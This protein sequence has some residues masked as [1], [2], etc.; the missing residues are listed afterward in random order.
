L[1]P[2]EELAA[3]VIVIPPRL[4]IIAVIHRQPRLMMELVVFAAKRL[5]NFFKF[6]ESNSMK[7]LIVDDN[8]QARQ[9][10]KD[11]VLGESDEFHECEDG[12]EALSVYA[13]FQPDFVLMDW[14]MKKVNGLVATRNIIDKFPKAKILIVTNFDETDLRQAAEEAGAIAFVN[15]ENLIELKEMLRR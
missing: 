5:S 12:A 9:M 2:V 14:E 7:I 4:R 13:D 3:V 15:K 1:P 6:S 8:P 11:Y 10:I